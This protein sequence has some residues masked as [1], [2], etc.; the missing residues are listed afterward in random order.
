ME[1]YS[2]GVA[3]IMQTPVLVLFLH[4]FQTVDVFMESFREYL[5][6]PTRFKS[7]L[8]PTGIAEGADIRLVEAINQ[9]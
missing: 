1:L 3:R 7:T 6:S 4:V 8:M 2:V 5:D 9:R